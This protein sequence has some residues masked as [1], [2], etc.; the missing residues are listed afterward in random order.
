RAGGGLRYEDHAV[1]SAECADGAIE[2]FAAQWVLGADGAGSAVRTLLGMPF[3]GFTWPER[4][5]AT[6]VFYPFEEEGYNQTTFLVDEKFGAIIVKIDNSARGGLWRYTYSEPAELPAEGVRDRMGEFFDTVMPRADLREL[7]AFSPYKMHQRCATTFRA[8][9][10]LLVGDAAHAT[11][12]TGGLGLTGGLFDTYFLIEA[13]AGVVHGT[14][15]DWVLD[16]YAHERRR[17]F[18]EFVSPA[19]SANKRLVFGSTATDEGRAAWQRVQRLAVDED[20]ARA[21]LMFPK[22]LETPVPV[23]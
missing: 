3:E 2:R 22:T 23:G 20:A 8:N 21:R 14:M 10:V 9:R 19:A 13:L 17:V 4:F 11:N 5:V 1:V 7:V 18:K 15:D 16:K 6:D 12:P